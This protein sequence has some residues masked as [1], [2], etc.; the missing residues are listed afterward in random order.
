MSTRGP[1]ATPGK[2]RSVREFAL[3]FPEE[4]VDLVFTTHM[5]RGY[6]INGPAVAEDQ[7]G[8]MPKTREQ[9]TPRQDENTVRRAIILA[10]PS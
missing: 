9:E 5:R 2:Y 3:A 7:N 1:G 8:V 6:I 10:S 4:E